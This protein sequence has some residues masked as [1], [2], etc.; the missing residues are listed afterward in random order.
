ME[1]LINP[2]PLASFQDSTV[3]VARVAANRSEAQVETDDDDDVQRKASYRAVIATKPQPAMRRFMN[4]IV[5]VYRE[6]S[7]TITAP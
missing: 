2:K 4:N 6:R 1:S 7:Y 5:R 3:P